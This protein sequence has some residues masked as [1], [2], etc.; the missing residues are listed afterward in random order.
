MSNPIPQIPL[1]EQLVANPQPKVFPLPVPMNVPEIPPRAQGIPPERGE[2]DE[3]MGEPG[4]LVPR[5]ASG[6]EEWREWEL[7]DYTEQIKKH[8]HENTSLLQQCMQGQV[9]MLQELWDRV[10]DKHTVLHEEAHQE[11]DWVEG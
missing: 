6:W 7:W 5:T 10:I 4:A 8:T 11:H 1:V 3:S 9:G 2:G